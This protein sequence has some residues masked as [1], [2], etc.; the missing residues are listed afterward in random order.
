[1]ALAVG[2][3]LL[4]IGVGFSSAFVTG[5]AS[6]YM[7]GQVAKPLDH[8]KTAR[9]LLPKIIGLGI[10]QTIFA[11][12]YML[13]GFGL[14]MLSAI[15]GGSTN[16]T[17]TGAGLVALLA[18]FGVAL[19]AIAFPIVLARQILM[20]PIVVIER[21][22]ILKAYRRNKELMKGTKIHPSGYGHSGTIS[23]LTYFLVLFIWGGSYSVAGIINI[24]ERIDQWLR[25]SAWHE[26]ASAAVKFLP[27]FVTLWTVI[28][29]WCAGATLLYYERRTRV[30]GYDIEALSQD[31]SKHVKKNRFEL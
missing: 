3:P 22:G 10:W 29:V 20:L 17:S 18:G 1:M 12:I 27:L 16:D 5:L 31:L 19:G 21:V 7:N 9:K 23:F 4:G 24:Q 28:P 30:E 14:L 6:D 11:S 25:G 26:L 15:I 8:V 2:A 13:G